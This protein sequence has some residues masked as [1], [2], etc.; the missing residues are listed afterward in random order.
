[1]RDKEA[2]IL[3]ECHQTCME[4]NK[5][6]IEKII[7]LAVGLKYRFQSMK[8]VLRKMKWNG[9]DERNY[10]ERKRDK[11]AEANHRW[12]CINKQ[13]RMVSGYIKHYLRYQDVVHFRQLVKTRVHQIIEQKK[14]RKLLLW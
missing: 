13:S 5:V 6:E 1:M 3:E 4:L 9:V 8:S 10:L 11:L 12:C 7:N 14:C 2:W